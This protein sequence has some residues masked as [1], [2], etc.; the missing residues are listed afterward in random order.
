MCITWRVGVCCLTCGCVF[1]YYLTCGCVWFDMWVCIMTCGC[2]WFDKWVCIIRHTGVYS[3][4]C[5]CVCVFHMKTCVIK[6]ECVLFEVWERIIWHVGAY[7]STCECILFDIWV[8]IKRHV[9]VDMYQSTCGCVAFDM[10]V[11]HTRISRLRES[12]LERGYVMWVCLS[13]EVSMC[14]RIS[15]E[16]GC[17]CAR[18]L[19]QYVGVL[20]S[21]F[22]WCESHSQPGICGVCFVRGMYV[23][24]CCL[25]VHACVSMLFVCG[26]VC[27]YV[28]CV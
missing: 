21:T 22:G 11:K 4:T 1:Q 7:Y 6:R 2:V 26:R 9:I 20:H 17:V 3:F 18:V 13:R 8:C 15:F 25:C 16:R 24:V 14:V 23:W 12:R 28:V 5:A 27:E 19:C 10:W